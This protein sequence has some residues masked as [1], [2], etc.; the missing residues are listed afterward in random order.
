M[1]TWLACLNEYRLR[2]STLVLGSE[3]CD[4]L[5]SLD[6]LRAHIAQ[7]ILKVLAR[8]RVYQNTHWHLNA[9]H[10]VGGALPFVK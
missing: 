3:L 7:A 2:P 1:T 10:V 5:M 4:R 6:F 9:S 8:D